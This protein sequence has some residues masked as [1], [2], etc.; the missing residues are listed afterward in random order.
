MTHWTDLVLYCFIWSYM[1]PLTP[2]QILRQIISSEHFYFIIISFLPNQSYTLVTATI[3]CWIILNNIDCV[4]VYRVRPN[5][6]LDVIFNV[7]SRPLLWDPFFQ[8]TIIAILRIS[9]IF[10][11][12]I[13]QDS[14]SDMDRT[15]APYFYIVAIF[16]S[17]MGGKQ[18]PCFFLSFFLDNRYL[19]PIV[20]H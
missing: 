11:D 13:I 4:Y 18:I 3:H 12:I 16:R 1:A 14:R 8:L 17:H 5:N 10:G 7:S 20:R 15:V 9:Y 2:M 6:H 19:P